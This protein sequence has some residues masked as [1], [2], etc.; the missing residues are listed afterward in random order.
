MS[1]KFLFW[2]GF[3]PL[4]ISLIMAVII[5]TLFKSLPPK[6]PLFYSLPWGEGQLAT[7]Q[8]FLIIP[9]SI[10]VMA[11]LNI[12]ISGQLHDQQDF[13]KKVLL[14]SS[15]AI[16]VTLTITFIKIILMFV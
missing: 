12:I 4:I 3:S 7:A 8:Q 15:I 2:M 9:A 11:L 1:Q 16:T 10:S 6:L 14:I 5:L 13:F